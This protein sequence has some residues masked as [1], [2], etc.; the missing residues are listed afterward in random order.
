MKLFDWLFAKTDDAAI[1][2]ADY[3]PADFSAELTQARKEIDRIKAEHIEAVHALT[4]KDER[5][6]ALEDEAAED[7]EA[8]KKAAEDLAAKEAELAEK[9]AELATKDAAIEQAE[10]SAEAKANAIL[11]QAGHAA[12]KIV[13]AKETED[14]VATYK[15][16]K[17]GPER[18]AFREKNK[19]ILLR[20]GAIK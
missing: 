6:K 15:A 18:L 11:A 14:V 20:A 9:D 17:A 10:Q 8:A 16:M 3:S 19:A 4:A 2:I 7:E 1:E 5:I 13:P 12:L